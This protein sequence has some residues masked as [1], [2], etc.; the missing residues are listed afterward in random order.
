MLTSAASPYNVLQLISLPFDVIRLKAGMSLN[1]KRIYQSE[2][3]ISASVKQPRAQI[4]RLLLSEKSDTEKLCYLI[5]V[6]F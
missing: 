3:R 2:L 1:L 6:G 4:A 5:S